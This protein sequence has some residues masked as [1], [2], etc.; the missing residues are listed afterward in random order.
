MSESAIEYSSA[1]CPPIIR[2]K[3]LT[4]NSFLCNICPSR[5]WQFSSEGQHHV[6]IASVRFGA[7]RSDKAVS[8]PLTKKTLQVHIRLELYL[9]ERKHGKSTGEAWSVQLASG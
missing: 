3:L 8:V 6:S 5:T 1:N 7:R 9:S 4:T 2:R